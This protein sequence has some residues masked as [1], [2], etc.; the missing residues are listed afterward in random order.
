[1]PEGVLAP[2]NTAVIG[3]VPRVLNDVVK[4]ALPMVVDLGTATIVPTPIVT[5]LSLNVIV[6]PIMGATGTALIVAVKVTDWPKVAFGA[7]LASPILV[8][9]LTSCT[10]EA[11]LPVM[12]GG[13]PA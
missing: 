2:A 12:L 7:E 8:N 3:W 11:M 4:V 10:T 13:T 9:T 6:W 1:M 5:P